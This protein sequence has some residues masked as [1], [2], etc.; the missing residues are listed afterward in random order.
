MKAVSMIATVLPFALAL[1]AVAAIVL[2][3]RR[4]GW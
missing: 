2:L 3:R 1:S 4:A